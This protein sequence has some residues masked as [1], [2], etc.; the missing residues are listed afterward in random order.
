MNRLERLAR[1]IEDF[2][3]WH[4]ATAEALAELMRVEL[5][6]EDP[7]VALLGASRVRFL[8]QPLPDALVVCAG[9][10]PEAGWQ[11]VARCALAEIPR[12]R[13]KLPSDPATAAGIRAFAERLRDEGLF[14]HVECLAETSSDDFAAAGAVLAFGSDDTVAAIRARV[15]WQTPFLGYGHKLS[16]GLV[17]GKDISADLAARAAADVA[18]RGQL[19]CLSP[20]AIYAVG[21]AADFAEM[22]AAALDPAVGQAQRG[23]P[24]IAAA[25]AVQAARSDALFRGL[26]VWSPGGSPAWTVVLER[27]PALRP[28]PAH[29]FVR[30][31]PARSIEE[32]AA[33]LRPL[34]RALS[35]VGMSTVRPFACE[36]TRF[37]PLGEMHRPPPLWRHDG[38]LTLA[39]MVRWVTVEEPAR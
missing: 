2:S 11:A 33:A 13:L 18:A 34:G 3:A 8:A 39:R 35:T 23:D 36:A 26:R 25:A 21:R 9:N 12:L 32:A 17:L 4:G 22:L 27:D 10:V 20:R 19:G 24:D 15:P 6:A 38:A 30:V 28:S 37:C 16:C 29:C 31:C 1:A 5:G 14:Q 7:F